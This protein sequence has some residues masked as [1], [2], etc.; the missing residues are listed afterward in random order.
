MIAT[1]SPRRFLDSVQLLLSVL[2]I[3]PILAAFDIALRLALVT[4]DE[5]RLRSFIQWCTRRMQSLIRVLWRLRFKVEIH[6]DLISKGSGG[7]IV[8]ANHQSPLDIL[9]LTCA[10]SSSPPHFVCRSGLEKGYPFISRYIRHRC[11]VMGSDAKANKA[12]LE[13]LG[14]HIAA[15]GG[16]AIIFPEGPKNERSYP[17][18]RRFQ[19]SG[20]EAIARNAPSAQVLSVAIQGTNA[21]WAS[22]NRLPKTGSTVQVAL[23]DR[24]RTCD[25]EPSRL[26]AHCETRIRHSLG[27]AAQP[28]TT[29]EKKW[30][31]APTH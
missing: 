23:A 9:V 5:S 25:V 28:R 30:I 10:F 26:A 3:P 27:C 22:R 13:K 21:A 12:A 4:G 16:V 8:V 20:L 2:V 6:P 17:E 18:F 24:I 31:S 11:V 19:R 15:T 29:P 14:R 7:T 1:E